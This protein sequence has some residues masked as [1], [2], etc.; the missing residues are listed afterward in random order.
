M[1]GPTGS[2]KTTTLYAA[3]SRINGAEKS[4]FTLEDP[5]E[6]QLPLV[7][8]TQVNESIGLTFAEGLRTLLRQ[9]PDVILVGETRDAETAQLAVRAALTGH[10]VFTTL[11]TNDALGAIPRLVDLGVEPYLLAPT[12]LGVLGQ[13]LVRRLCPDCRKPAANVEATLNRFA[14]AANHGTAG[15]V[16]EPVGCPECRNTGFRGRVGIYELVTVDSATQA[17]IAAGLDNGRLQDLARSNGFRSM[18]ED[19]LAKVAQGLTTIEEVMR[20]TR[21]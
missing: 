13:R 15:Q 12:L 6:F 11:H 5:V 18:F 10:L 20:V 19:G 4:I 21:N 16:F 17:S 8:Q 7:R 2:G 14:L 9:D 1:T 3:L